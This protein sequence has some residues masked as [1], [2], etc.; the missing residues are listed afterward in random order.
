MLL[1]GFSEAGLRLAE[2]QRTR[3][4]YVPWLTSHNSTPRSY[5][6]EV[7]VSRSVKIG[8]PVVFVSMNYR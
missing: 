7:I 6:G 8:E 4:L 2:L 3:I 1:S 5:K